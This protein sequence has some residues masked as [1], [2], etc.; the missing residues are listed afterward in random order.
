[1]FLKFTRRPLPGLLL[2]ACAFALLCSCGSDAENLRRAAVEET[3]T[4]TEET[5]PPP[6]PEPVLPE[7]PQDWEVLNHMRSAPDNEEA[8]LAGK[9]LMVTAP[10]IALRTAGEV[11]IRTM[12]DLSK[13]QDRILLNY[14]LRKDE[15]YIAQ[16]LGQGMQMDYKGPGATNDLI[17]EEDVAA[18]THTWLETRLQEIGSITRTEQT[19]AGEDTLLVNLTFEVVNK[20]AGKTGIIPIV[21]IPVKARKNRPN[22]T[23][24]KRVDHFVDV[25]LNYELTLSRGGETESH[26]GSIAPNYEDYRL[27]SYITKYRQFGR[28]LSMQLADEVLLH[29]VRSPL[30][31][32]LAVEVN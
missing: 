16:G 25:Q 22:Q 24:D 7:L 12:N 19:S 8:V 28:M 5:A 26:A 4:I 17:L 32:S 15:E 29:V 10:P 2:L 30:M 31:E 13:K 18:D 21:H 11:T 6:E 27:E 14:V 9:G 20:P 23:I 1:M 3:E